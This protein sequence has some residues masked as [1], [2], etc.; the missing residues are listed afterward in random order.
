VKGKYDV[1]GTCK[2]FLVPA[3]IESNTEGEIKTLNLNVD[4]LLRGC[5]G[6]DV[7]EVNGKG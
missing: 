4:H 6:F 5:S 7:V 2:G 3:L 1:V